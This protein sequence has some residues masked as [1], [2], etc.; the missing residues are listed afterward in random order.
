M[1][2]ELKP[3]GKYRDSGLQWLGP[4]PE[5]WEARPA[6]NVFVPNRERN[7]GLKERTVLSLSYGRI[8][9][10]PTEKVR[11][12]VPESFETYQIVNPGDI[13]LRT[14][15]LQNDHASLRVGMVRNRGIITSA[16]LA[17]CVKPGLTPEFGYQFLN[18]WDS[19]KAIYGHGSGL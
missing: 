10:K 15:D 14:T 19:T 2:S 7:R 9:I 3:Y 6:F 1:I 18:V 13:V 16:Y 5:H 11:G 17:L 8:I 4:I 12:L